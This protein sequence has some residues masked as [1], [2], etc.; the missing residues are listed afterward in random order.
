VADLT[1]AT[2]C[3][4]NTAYLCPAIRVICKHTDIEAQLKAQKL[5]TGGGAQGHTPS[6]LY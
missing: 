2:V 6:K 3:C 4:T 1:I 5:P